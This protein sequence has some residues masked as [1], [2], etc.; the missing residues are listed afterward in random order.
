MLSMDDYEKLE[1]LLYDALSEKAR[2]DGTSAADIECI[3]NALSGLVKIDKLRDGG[4]SQRGGDWSANMRGTYGGS[5]GRDGEHYVRGHYSRDGGNS[6]DSG[7]VYS[8]DGL[9]DKLGELMSYA[10]TEEERRAMQRCM[11]SLR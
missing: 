3:K 1:R 11:E 9:M 10:G 5:Y 4:Y 6:Y 2:K 8:R 7:R